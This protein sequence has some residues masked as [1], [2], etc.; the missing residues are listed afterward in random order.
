MSI[1]KNKDNPLI[2][3]TC[4]NPAKKSTLRGRIP[5]NS[6][7]RI[8][9]SP[10]SSIR[11]SKVPKKSTKSST[12]SSKRTW[13]WTQRVNCCSNRSFWR[14]KSIKSTPGA[15]ITIWSKPSAVKV[16]FT[17]SWL[18]LPR[19]VS[20]ARNS[21]SR[22]TKLHGLA[23]RVSYDP[24]LLL[25]FRSDV[26]Y[27]HPAPRNLWTKDGPQQTQTNPSKIPR[28]TAKPPR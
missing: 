8:S 14:I 27:E 10:R 19:K 9:L 15:I 17:G 13:I 28:K 23:F 21:R 4:T 6:R 24:K 5:S 3:N 12:T 18:I 20:Y 7:K 22:A 16:I 11:S 25:W 2:W 1:Y 26:L